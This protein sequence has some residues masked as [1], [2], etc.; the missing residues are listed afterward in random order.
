MYN[1]CAG[2]RMPA[3]ASHSKQQLTRR[4]MGGWGRSKAW[5]QCAPT[6]PRMLAHSNRP[7]TTSIRMRPMTI[8]SRR[9]VCALLLWSRSLRGEEGQME[10]HNFRLEIGQLGPCSDA[11][12]RA[13]VASH[14]QS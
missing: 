4:I 14:K 1:A 8:H 5:C 3:R 12:A 7:T 6:H 10:E 11:A 9:E 2:K 13:R